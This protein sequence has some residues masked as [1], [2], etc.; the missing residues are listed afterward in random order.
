MRRLHGCDD[1]E[2]R[3]S[4]EIGGCDDLCVF[5]AVAAVAGPLALATASKAIESDGVGAVAD[6]VEVELEAG[7]VAVDRPSASAWRDRSS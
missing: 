3:E 4:S 6:G 2:R 5:D 1:V 7:F